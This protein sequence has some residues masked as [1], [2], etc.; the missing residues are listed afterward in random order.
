V[1]FEEY[2]GFVTKYVIPRLPEEARG[3]YERIVEIGVTQA[4]YLR[5]RMWNLPTKGLEDTEA[6][7]IAELKEFVAQLGMNN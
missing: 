5:C 4:K 6:E 7:R 1:C 2:A 3:M